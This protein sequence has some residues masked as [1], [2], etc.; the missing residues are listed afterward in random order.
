MRNID[1][2]IEDLPAALRFARAARDLTQEEAH[3]E[4]G[5]TR[6]IINRIEKEHRPT[7][8]AMSMRTFKAI[9]AWIRE[10]AKK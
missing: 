8:D 6:Q 7:L 2:R 5:I 3:V 9:E 4:I 10:G 1:A